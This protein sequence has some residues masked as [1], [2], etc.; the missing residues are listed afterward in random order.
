MATLQILIAK[1]GKAR[2]YTPYWR[3]GEQASCWLLQLSPSLLEL[4]PLLLELLLLV[5]RHDGE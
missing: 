1:R 3:E 2:A 5:L 4:L